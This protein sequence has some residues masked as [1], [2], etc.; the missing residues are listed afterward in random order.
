MQLRVVS[1][2]VMIRVACWMLLACL[3]FSMMNGIVRHLGGVLEPIVVVFFRCLFGLIA[4]APFL[5]RSGFS[6][7]RTEKPA[8]HVIRGF[9]ETKTENKLRTF[10]KRKTFKSKEYTPYDSGR[11]FTVLLRNNPIYAYSE[12]LYK[13]FLTVFNKH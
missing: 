8:L 3:C 13:S 9:A 10:I 11:L 2:S 7:L 12:S 6:S 1:P 5:L 4:M